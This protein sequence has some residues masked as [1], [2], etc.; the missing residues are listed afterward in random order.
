MVEHDWRK[1][2]VVVSRMDRGDKYVIKQL[3][4]DDGS[5]ARPR[6]PQADELVGLDKETVDVLERA[7]KE[8]KSSQGQGEGYRAKYRVLNGKAQFRD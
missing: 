3:S 6:L 8:Q 2:R 5:G 1:V 4:S 7:L